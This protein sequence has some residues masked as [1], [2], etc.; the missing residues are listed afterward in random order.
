MIAMLF[1]AWQA[2]FKWGKG[3]HIFAIIEYEAL[4]L[5][6]ATVFGMAHWT[7]LMQREWAR[8]WASAASIVLLL[9]SVLSL[10]KHSP[11]GL[12]CDLFVAAAG[13]LGVVSFARGTSIL[14]FHEP[15]VD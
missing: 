10:V 7:V 3:P 9:M 4:L 2:G 5:P 12:G 6:F 8:A 14:E 13:L 15:Q 1:P 11:A